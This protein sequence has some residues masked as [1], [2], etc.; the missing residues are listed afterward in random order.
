[1]PRHDI[2]SLTDTDTACSQA[3]EPAPRCAQDRLRQPQSRTPPRPLA[4]RRPATSPHRSGPSRPP[5]PRHRPLRS[6]YERST[7]ARP[8]AGP[9]PPRGPPAVRS[10]DA[11]PATGER[12]D[13]SI[14]HCGAFRLPPALL[15]QSRRSRLSPPSSRLCSARRSPRRQTVRCR[16]RPRLGINARARQGTASSA[17]WR[18]CAERRGFQTQRS[19]AVLVAVVVVSLGLRWPSVAEVVATARQADKQPNPRAY[20][21]IP[22]VRSDAEPHQ[23]KGQFRPGTPCAVLPGIDPAAAEPIR[24]HEPECGRRQS[25]RAI[26]RQGGRAQS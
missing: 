24:P 8:R 19:L 5:A 2:G 22:A 23:R 3:E 9:K 11:R 16:H 10:G 6:A 7:N 14:W 21:G 1:M 25:K 17:N 20:R 13:G 26:T 18:A 4:P 15:T 12:N